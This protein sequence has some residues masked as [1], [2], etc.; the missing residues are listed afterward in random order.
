M[1]WNGLELTR[2]GYDGLER[3]RTDSNWLWRPGTGWLGEGIHVGVPN[4]HAVYLGLC[5]VIHVWE[6]TWNK[7]KKIKDHINI[8]NKCEMFLKG[9]GHEMNIFWRPIKL[10]QYFLYMRIWFYFYAA[11]LKVDSKEKCS[12][13]EP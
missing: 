13:V 6:G 7:Y 1:A 10:N 2:T 11:L 4:C 8:V 9:L 12:V 5:L 3:V